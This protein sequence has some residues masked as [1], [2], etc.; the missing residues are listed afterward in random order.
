MP[1]THTFS[2]HIEDLQ[3]KTI[4]GILPQ[5]RIEQQNIIVDLSFEYLYD[6]SNNDFIDYSVVVEDLK[7]IFHEKKFELIEEA[8]IY[9]EEFLTTKYSINNFKLK[10]VKPDI[11]EDCNVGVSNF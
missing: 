6:S 9:I 3:F 7:N 5:E 10:I 2:I 4:I 11:L 1:K 8:L